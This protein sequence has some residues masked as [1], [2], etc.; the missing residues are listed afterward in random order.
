MICLCKEFSVSS[1][2][3]HSSDWHIEQKGS[4]AVPPAATIVAW[5]TKPMVQFKS[6]ACVMHHHNQ[7]PVHYNTLLPYDM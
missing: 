3:I 7:C 5:V 4:N 6:F 2:N 1:F